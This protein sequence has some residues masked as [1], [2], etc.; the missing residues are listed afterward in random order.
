[1]AILF[2]ADLHLNEKEPIITI[3][4]LHFLS[5]Q[6]S[7]AKALYILGDFFDY[8]IGDDYQNSLHKTIAKK[9]KELQNKGVLCYFIHGNRDF[10]INKKFAKES[11]LTL[12]SEEKVLTLH[13]YTILILHGDTLCTDNISYQRYRKRVC[14][15]YLQKLFLLLP[16]S[17]R[18]FILKKIRKNSQSRAQFNLKYF[19]DV[20]K[21]TVINKFRKY[22]VDLMIHGHTHQSAIHKIN[23]DTRI[24]YRVVLGDWHQNG[25][26]IKIT[27]QTIEL[28]HFPFY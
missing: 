4:F 8:W 1:M 24:L 3:G 22:Q 12:L 26:V 14:N 27:P 5:E 10:L 9:L 18:Y 7:H 19:R 11:G 15:R 13:G 20:N 16:L 28:I 23:I 17:I 25:S 2:I 6:A 21:Q